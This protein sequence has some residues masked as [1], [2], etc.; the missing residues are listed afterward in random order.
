LP[1]MDRPDSQGICFL[2]KI[3]YP[4]FVRFHLGEKT[5]DIIDIATGKKLAD[6]KGVWF[7][8]VGQRKGLG[9]GGGPWYVVKKD[10]DENIVYVAHTEKYLDHAREEFTVA[11]LHWISRPPLSNNL[12]T[13]VRHSPRL[14]QCAIQDI[15]GARLAVRLATKDQ[16]IAPGQSAVF[17]DGEYCLGTGV[18][19]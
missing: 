6:H 19:E 4:E 14:E 10:M 3:K 15:G 11:D 9:M 5:G 16:G 2:G 1:N 7:H 13:K 12:L 8:T 18:I 17:Y